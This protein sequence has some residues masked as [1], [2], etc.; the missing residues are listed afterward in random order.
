MP[1][2]SF[3]T[4]DYAPLADEVNPPF[5]R[6]APAPISRNGTIVYS[7]RSSAS[8]S[9]T[10]FSSYDRKGKGRAYDDDG[11]IGSRSAHHAAGSSNS[12]Q[13]G[14]PYSQ[15][16]YDAAEE[17]SYPPLN[18]T[19]EEEKRIQANLAK[20][21]ARDSA[22]RKAARVSRIGSS[23]S[24]SRPNSITSTSSS[25]HRSQPM[26]P[27]S[28]LS[29][30]SEGKR[31][32]LL[33]LSRSSSSNKGKEREAEPLAQ[34][35]AQRTHAHADANVNP[36]APSMHSSS[37]FADPVDLPPTPTDA[38]GY[39][40]PRWRGGAAATEAPAPRKE[41]W[42]HSLCAWGADLDGGDSNQAGRT[43]PME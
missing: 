39:V 35:D 40:G 20:F 16:R 15:G 7:K 17:P 41:R 19:E 23:P 22:R 43:N 5:G 11:D 10:S 21:A 29:P 13:G 1:S 3:S 12:W 31:T 8:G 37:P 32:S 30:I 34:T 42:W 28:P 27:M 26:S 36:Y 6:V 25:S 18:E 14:G 33:G 4:K 38:D 2:G 9:D 24:N